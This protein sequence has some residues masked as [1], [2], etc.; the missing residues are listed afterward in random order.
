[1]RHGLLPQH[2]SAPAPFPSNPFQPLPSPRRAPSTCYT[3]TCQHRLQLTEY[4]RAY[5]THA[6]LGAAPAPRAALALPRHVLPPSL[7]TSS[8]CNRPPWLEQSLPD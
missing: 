3:A 5:A 8:L 2:T 7:L 6:V 4:K 1:M